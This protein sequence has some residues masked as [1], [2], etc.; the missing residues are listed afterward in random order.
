MTGI[1]KDTLTIDE[2]N[3]VTPSET[4]DMLQYI[5]ELEEAGLWK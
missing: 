4:V 5:N 3:A 2:L 1:N